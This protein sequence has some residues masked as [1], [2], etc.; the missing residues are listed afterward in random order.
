MKGM[1]KKK[2]G[3][4]SWITFIKKRIDS[5]LNFLAITT[6]G[7]GAGKS[8]A[9]LS[10]AHQLDPEFDPVYQVAFD[11]PSFMKAINRFNGVDKSYLDEAPTLDSE[12]EKND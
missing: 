1:I 9:D 11:F 6:G 5:N 4:G 2:K 8:Y 7:P 3:E 10:I 12:D